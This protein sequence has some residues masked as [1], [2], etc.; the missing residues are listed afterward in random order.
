[1]GLTLRTLHRK[2]VFSPTLVDQAIAQVQ[3]TNS[4]LAFLNRSNL[5]SSIEPIRLTPMGMN[6]EGLARVWSLFSF[7]SKF[8]LALVYQ[9]S[10][11]FVDADDLP[12]TALPVKIANVYVDAGGPPVIDSVFPTLDVTGPVKPGA[13]LSIAG[14]GF[15]TT[16]SDVQVVLDG[17]EIPTTSVTPTLITLALPAALPAGTHRLQVARPRLMGSPPEPHQGLLSNSAAI[18]L[19]PAVAS[20]SVFFVFGDPSDPTDDLPPEIIDGVT[21]VSGHIQVTVTPPVEARQQVAILLN[22]LQVTAGPTARAYTVPVAARDEASPP[23]TTVTAQFRRVVPGTYLVRVQVDG[24]TSALDADP[25][26]GRFATP[27]VPVPLPP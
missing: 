13:A 6:L 26:T 17:N 7:Q 2:P 3:T 4:G 12:R 27:F 23:S 14:R 25:A 9:A 5:A 15:G 22:E 8:A 24:A 19:Q 11:L 1:M 18:V 21:V 10:M 20:S 16:P